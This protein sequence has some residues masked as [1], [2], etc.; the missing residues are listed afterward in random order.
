MIS[1]KKGL[2]IGVLIALIIIISLIIGIVII[3][4]MPE[5]KVKSLL[6]LGDKYLSEMNYEDAIAAFEA[7]IEIEP[8]TEAAYIGIANAYIGLGNYE[9]ALD[10]VERGISVLGETDNLIELKAH[11]EEL[12]AQR[13]KEEKE[14][15][16]AE[17]EAKRQASAENWD[18]DLYDIL[19]YDLFGKDVAEWT[20]E[21]FEAYIEDNGYAYSESDE[22]Q[23]FAGRQGGGVSFCGGEIEIEYGAGYI[24]SVSER[25]FSPETEASG[26]ALHFDFPALNPITE[27][28]FL[29]RL[30]AEISEKLR[31]NKQYAYF[32]NGRCYR[33]EDTFSTW[34]V[35]SHDETVPEKAVRAYFFIVDNKA[36]CFGFS[37]D[38]G[39][40]LQISAQMS[41]GDMAGATEDLTGDLAREGD[42]DIT[43]YIAG[44]DFKSSNWGDTVEDVSKVESDWNDF[45]SEDS[46][47]YPG[48]KHYSKFFESKYGFTQID[49]F[50]DE[51]GKLFQ[52]GFQTAAFDAGEAVDNFNELRDIFK[53]KLGS[54]YDYRTVNCDDDDDSL[55]DALEKGNGFALAGWQLGDNTRAIVSVIP[56]SPLYFVKI[57]YYNQDESHNLDKGVYRIWN[58]LNPD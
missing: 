56:M 6:S 36:Y 20:E 48:C 30:P 31:Q 2:I 33:I 57:G 1:K 3:K 19:H 14:A 52:G 42:T 39:E 4:I 18:F 29:E 21:E 17:E 45:E 51:E 13:E 11:I 9:K 43:V 44:C 41:E 34:S 25:S 53:E 28:E 24:W 16:E 22:P 10:A 7:A 54:G 47:D 15:L 46:T 49:Y 37:S 40:L 23:Y 27:S 5:R 35:Y 58:E 55:K 26:S 50:F 38:N 8:K 32:A 12:I